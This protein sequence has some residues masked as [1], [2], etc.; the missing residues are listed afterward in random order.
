MTRQESES[1]GDVLTIG[2][3][4]VGPGARIGP[5]VYER[6]VGRGGMAWVLLARDPNRQPVALKVL[7]ASRLNTGQKRFK[8]EFHALVR[9]NHPNVIRVESYGD[10]YGH[11][12]IAMEYV[13]GHD[14]HQLVRSFKGMPHQMRWKRCDRILVDLCRALAHIHRRGLV[15][16]DLKPSNILLDPQGRAKLTD[17]GIVKDLDPSADP[18]VSNT[19]VGTWAY[20]SPEQI[21]GDPI[22]HRSDLYSLGVILFVMLTGRR[23]FVA[24][25]IAGYLELHKDH[26]PP[27]PRELVPQVP[28]YLDEICVRLMR[29]APRDR[30]QSAQEVLFTVEHANEDN[31]H[32]VVTR[33]R[34]ENE[35][36]LPL[37]GRTLELA[38]L[39]EVLADL[40]RGQGS[41]LWVLGPVGCGRTRL[42]ELCVHQ[43]QRLGFPVHV[44]RTRESAGPFGALERLTAELKSDLGPEFPP[45]LEEAVKAFNRD[46]GPVQGDLRYR[47]FDGLRL[48]L[49]RALDNGPR[50]VAVDDLHLAP[51]AV[52]D[53]LAYIM[54]T[55]VGKGAPLLIIGSA[56]TDLPDFSVDRLTDPS[57]LGSSP[58]VLEPG[59]LGQGDLQDLIKSIL[60]DA[61]GSRALAQR[62]HRETEGNPLFVSQFLQ[63][64][65]QRGIITAS[66]SGLALAIDTEEVRAGHLEIPAGIRSV[67]GTRLDAVPAEQRGLLE[68]LAVNGRELDL[69]VLLDVVGQDEDIVLDRLDELMDARILVEHRQGPLVSIDFTHGKFGD[70]IYRD[71]EPDRRVALHRELAVIHEERSGASAA[72]AELIGEHYRRGGEAGKA[73]LH[74]VVAAQR[75]HERSLQV[76]AWKLSEQAIAVEDTAKADLARNAF[77]R[78]R[79]DLLRTRADVIYGRG[80]WSKARDLLEEACKLA[81]RLALDSEGA[82]MK[83]RLSR[84]EAR[85]GN[86]VQS[87]RLLAQALEVGRANK[88]RGLITDVLQGMAAAAWNQGDLESCRARTSEGLVLAVGSELEGARAELLLGHTAVQAALGHLAEATEGLTEAEGILKKLGLKR[89]RVL[90]LANLAELHTWQG[91]LAMALNCGRRAQMLAREVLFRIGEG[92]AAR[93]SGEVAHE[94]G[95]MEEA[96]Q[97][98]HEALDIVGPLQIKSELIATRYAIGRYQLERGQVGMAERHLS[99]ARGLAAQLDPE[100]YLPL[101][102]ATLAYVFNESGDRFQA[103]QILAQAMERRGGVPLP[104]QIKALAVAA[105]AYIQLGENDKACRAAR[106]AT[107]LA[108][109]RGLRL[110]ALQGLQVLAAHTEDPL[111]AR[112]AREASQRLA[113]ELTMALPASLKRPFEGRPGIRE[114]L[115]AQD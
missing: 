39:K 57:L 31:S 95:L 47:V 80:E 64:L 69:D 66:P 37:V 98:L 21:C 16:R 52:F 86:T 62:L 90:A 4:Q 94:L 24:K 104:Q 26:Q 102:Q 112:R 115:D 109:E 9:I 93:I 8:R 81:D 92:A 110:W 7:R 55:V 71:L 54:R 78:I 114:L 25:D 106:Q 30:F 61:Q 10:I 111:E 107:E 100:G 89:S 45:D 20:A 14:L 108:Q 29:K 1:Q 83:L 50:V 113:R 51:G 76:E 60:G 27:R 88:D 46:Q 34:D 79:L 87:D 40:M 101:I 103:E 58:R 48:A 6:L 11:P 72:A 19:L 17:F 42:I 28:E 96:R 77:R 32:S 75:F 82:R 53:L 84:A 73:Y 23:P 65:M 2:G 38:S 12:Y 33:A 56:R 15:H 35:W 68:V 97:R 22:D 44:T 85:L 105:R 59:P 74:L 63:T 67:L 91:N 3:L 5:Y 49:E 13:E 70:I 41:A 43:A 99:I 36:E 18:N